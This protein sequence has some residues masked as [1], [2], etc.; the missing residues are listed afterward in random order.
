MNAATTLSNWYTQSFQKEDD[1]LDSVVESRGWPSFKHL[2]PFL[3]A[4]K[5]NADSTIEETRNKQIKEAKSAIDELL[6]DMK[7]QFNEAV[8][9]LEKENFDLYVENR[10]IEEEIEQDIATI[11]EL[12]LD[13]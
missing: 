1:K 3:F 8:T 2:E 6:A 5:N 11:L 7:N 13:E 4:E 9:E 12:I 10:N